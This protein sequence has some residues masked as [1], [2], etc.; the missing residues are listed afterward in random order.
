LGAV[1]AVL[2]AT[3]VSLLGGGAWLGV[4]HVVLTAG[5]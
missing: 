1:A 4:P 5:R 2:A 3:A